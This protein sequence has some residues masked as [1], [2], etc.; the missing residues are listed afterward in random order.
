MATNKERLE[1][2]ES[3]Y[4]MMQDEMQMMKG[5]MIDLKGDLNGS[6]AKWRSLSND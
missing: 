3:S 6:I 1:E 2:L 4:G 5:D